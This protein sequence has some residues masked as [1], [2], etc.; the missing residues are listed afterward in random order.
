MPGLLSL[1][2]QIQQ[3]TR[4][5]R[6][7]TSLRYLDSMRLARIRKRL[8]A[9]SGSRMDPHYRQHRKRELEVPQNDPALST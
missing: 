7:L 5:P 6:Y 4:I 3:G 2:V 1:A 9:T 8:H